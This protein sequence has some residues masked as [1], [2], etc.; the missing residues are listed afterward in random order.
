[1]IGLKAQILLS[2]KNRII[3]G[4]QVGSIRRS[5]PKEDYIGASNK[6]ETERDEDLTCLASPRI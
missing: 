2:M 6:K 5:I 4:K 1:M 3:T